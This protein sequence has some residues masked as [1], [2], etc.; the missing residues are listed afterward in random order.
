M[1]F[2]IFNRLA[3]PA[4]LLAVGAF[5]QNASA[6]WSSLHGNNRPA[7]QQSAPRPQSPPVYHAPAPQV[8]ETPPAIRPEPQVH[9]EIQ[10]AHE[11]THAVE[12][13]RPTPAAVD[14]AREQPPAYHTQA[15][16]TDRRRMDIDED[17]RQ[18]YYWSDYHRGMRVERLPDGYH[19]FHFHDHDY[20]YFEGVFY[21]SGPSG[22][23]VIDPP[24]D[25]DI[26]DVP[27]GAETVQVNGTVYYYADGT[28][29]VQQA[30]GSYVVA[31][32]PIG[33]TV[34]ML[35]PDATAVVIN[36]ATYYQA[37]GTYYLPVMQNGVTAYLTVAQPG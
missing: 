22:Y 2:P 33:V 32:A 1:K 4:T 3:L 11:P 35:S 5:C 34:S 31:A 10:P 28:F 25:A 12:P 18:S 29:Y 13:V 14:R 23:V 36:G 37:D 27:P 17:R 26:P 20:F 15:A 16:E 7:P 9:Q 21:D 8:H 6:Q 19:R 30:D 24:I